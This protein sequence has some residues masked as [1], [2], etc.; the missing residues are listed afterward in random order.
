MV[1]RQQ[2]PTTTRQPRDYGTTEPRAFA[3]PAQFRLMLSKPSFRAGDDR[4]RCSPRYIFITDSSSAAYLLCFPLSLSYKCFF[5]LSHHSLSIATVQGI[6]MNNQRGFQA[7]PL[8]AGARLRI[9]TSNNRKF[10]SFKFH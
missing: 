1:T 2:Q 9:I 10:S 8:M 5:S 6:I 7:D 4:S 3:T